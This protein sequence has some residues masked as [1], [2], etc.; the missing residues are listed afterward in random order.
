[1]KAIECLAVRGRQ[2]RFRTLHGDLHA[3]WTRSL[4]RRIF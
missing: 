3:T 4:S 2:C 1:V